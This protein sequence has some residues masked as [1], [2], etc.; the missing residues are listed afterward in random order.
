MYCFYSDEMFLVNLAY[1]EQFFFK[2]KEKC[3]TSLS[4]TCNIPL[5]WPLPSYFTYISILNATYS[6]TSS[7]LAETYIQHMEHKQIYPILIKQQ[8]IA[9]FRYV[10]DMIYKHRK[11]TQQ[12]HP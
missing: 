10:D 1:K 3:L 12:I 4:S 9:Y 6:P 8:I 11:N 7:I 2:K 5:Q